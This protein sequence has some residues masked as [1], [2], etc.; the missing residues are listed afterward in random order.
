M[1]SIPPFHI[2]AKIHSRAQTSIYRAVRQADNLPV[3]LE[4]LDKDHPTQEER[5]RFQR[6]YE[7]A[8]KMNGEGVI[9]LHEI[10]KYTTLWRHD[11]LV[12]R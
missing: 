6:E 10:Q 4:L 11:V 9:H 3:V 12:G 7:M 8:R 2:I 5:S 1:I